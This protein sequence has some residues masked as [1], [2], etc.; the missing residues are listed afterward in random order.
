M[1]Y[2]IPVSKKMK[3]NNLKNHLYSIKAK[4]NAIPYVTSYYEKWGFCLSYNQLKKLKDKFYTVK[5]D[6]ELKKGF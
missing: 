4:P 2:S 1:S 6:S 3:L 5:I